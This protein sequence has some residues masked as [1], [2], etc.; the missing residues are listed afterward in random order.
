MLEKNWAVIEQ[1][2]LE[3]AIQSHPRH[4]GS[5]T[6]PSRA[7]TCSPRGIVGM[8]VRWT[9]RGGQKRVGVSNAAVEN[10]NCWSIRAGESEPLSKV[11]APSALLKV[12]KPEE[13]CRRVRCNPQLG[14]CA[15]SSHQPRHFAYRR[16]RQDNFALGETQP[17]R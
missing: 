16:I 1:S 8:G 3:I 12:W 13:D 7:V 5:V 9:K 10:T 4:C 15:R 2:T 6:L 11:A 17:L 14:N